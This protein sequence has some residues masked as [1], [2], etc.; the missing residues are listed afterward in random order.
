MPILPLKG[1]TIEASG[2]LMCSL[3][4]AVHSTFKLITIRTCSF[5]GKGLCCRHTLS[6]SGRSEIFELMT[7]FEPVMFFV[8]AYKAGAFDRSATSARLGITLVGVS[9]SRVCN[10]QQGYSEF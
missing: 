3:S 9:H 6:Y 5:P 1:R 4:L 10:V 7:G 2:Y 8:P